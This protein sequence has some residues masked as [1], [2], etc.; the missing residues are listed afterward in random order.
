MASRNKS[1][2]TLRIA[3]RSSSPQQDAFA[4]LLPKI[5]KATS[6]LRALFGGGVPASRL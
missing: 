6:D 2:I 1:D 5:E 4:A 3:L